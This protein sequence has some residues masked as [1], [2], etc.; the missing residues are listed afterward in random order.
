MNFKTILL[1]ALTTISTVATPVTA[2]YQYQ[3][4]HLM[5]GS[6]FKGNEVLANDMILTSWV[7]MFPLNTSW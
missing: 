4:I 3:G 5:D 2:G 7:F 1:S 6:D